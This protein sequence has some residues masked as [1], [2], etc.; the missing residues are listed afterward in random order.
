MRPERP[1]RGPSAA[2]GSQRAARGQPKGSQ[3]QPSATE[4]GPGTTRADERRPESILSIVVESDHTESDH[5]G[6]QTDMQRPDDGGRGTHRTA[7]RSR[8]RT[9]AAPGVSLAALL[10]GVLLATARGARAR[11][12]A[13][14]HARRRQ[15]HRR[16]HDD[17]SGA[18]V[19]VLRLR[20]D[21]ER[22]PEPRRLRSGE[23]RGGLPA[24]ARRELGDVRGRALDHLHDGH[25]ARPS[26]RA[27]RSPPRMPSSRCAA[28]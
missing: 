27:I 1:G 25:R 26:R 10:G 15:P 11:R 17:R 9:G 2:K 23:P 5:T 16:H 13:A 18:V 14:E 8:R 4:C 21:Q 6:R 3:G 7:S 24:R 12:D 22:L 19:R 28:R 20:R